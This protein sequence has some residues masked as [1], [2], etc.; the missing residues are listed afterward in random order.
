[1][2]STNYDRKI[3]T[4]E[5]CAKTFVSVS[6]Y[7]KHIKHKIC[8][9]GNTPGCTNRA[10]RC[11]Q[12]RDSPFHLSCPCGSRFKLQGNYKTHINQCELPENSVTFL[13]STGNVIKPEQNAGL[14]KVRNDA[15]YRANKKRLREKARLN[16]YINKLQN[17]QPAE[18][19]D[20]R[21]EEEDTEEVFLERK[22]SIEL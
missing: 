17:L 2:S 3:G 9:G 11:K 4:C 15:Y 19:S 12:L 21:E 7:E 5:F 10:V 1:M 13:E 6:G 20:D 22:R 14:R 18:L 16:Y 8:R